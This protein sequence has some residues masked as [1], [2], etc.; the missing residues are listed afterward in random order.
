MSK[1][2]AVTAAGCFDVAQP[3]MRLRKI[4]NNTFIVAIHTPPSALRKVYFSAICLDCLAG[5]P[6]K[7]MRVGPGSQL[8][9]R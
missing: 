8:R 9:Q 6:R 2:L 1:F 3:T 4:A 5:G 7:V